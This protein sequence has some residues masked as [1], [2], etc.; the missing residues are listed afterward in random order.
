MDG[1]HA[2]R[3][4]VTA[5]QQARPEHVDRAYDDSGLVGIARP[6]VINQNR[7]AAKG[8][9]FEYVPGSRQALQPVSDRFQDGGAGGVYRAPDFL[10]AGAGLVDYDAAIHHERDSSRED[11]RLHRER[12]NA[13][14]DDRALARPRRHVYRAR[15]A[16]LA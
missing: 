7:A 4:P 12:E 9:D 5:K 16:L 15:Q 3:Y 11:V 8:C 10:G 13:Y 2:G 1:A 6:P 14:V